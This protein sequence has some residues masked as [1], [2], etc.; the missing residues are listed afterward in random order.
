MRCGHNE[1][2]ALG[3]PDDYVLRCGCG[4]IFNDEIDW[5]EARDDW[6]E[7]NTFERT[8]LG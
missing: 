7:E 6:A 2:K 3:D 8:R 4:V 1:V 5:Q